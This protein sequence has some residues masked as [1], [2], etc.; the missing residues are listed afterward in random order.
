MAFLGHIDR[1]FGDFHHQV[2]ISD[3]GLAGEPGLRFQ[4]PGF[5]EQVVFFFVRSLKRVKAFAH[6]NVASGAGAG[7][8]AGVFD[9]DAVGEQRV[10]NGDAGLGIQHR[11]IGAQFNV[12]KDDELG[13]LE[14]R[15]RLLL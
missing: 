3:D 2:L 13:H 15:C 5:V 11:A 8:F 9:F 14:A 6:H 10:A 1:I 12:G 4:P 7:F